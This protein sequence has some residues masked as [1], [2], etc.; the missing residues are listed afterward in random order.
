[1]RSRAAKTR[2]G[3]ALS[4]F[5]PLSRA[6]PTQD[7][8]RLWWAR[9]VSPISQARSFR[10]LADLA[11]SSP[12]L[13]RPLVSVLDEAALPDAVKQLLGGQRFTTVGSFL[14]QSVLH[15]LLQRQ[16][17][18]EITL[19]GFRDWLARGANSQLRLVS[20]GSSGE[21]ASG[22]STVGQLCRAAA[23]PD[24]DEWNAGM[25]SPA[26]PRILL[27]KTL[28]ALAQ[29]RLPLQAGRA[30]VDVLKGL[31]A[32]AK[33]GRATPTPAPPSTGN[34]RLDAFRH[35]LATMRERLREGWPPGLVPGRLQL[36]AERDDLELDLSLVGDERHLDRYDYSGQNG[37]YSQYDGAE[38][39]DDL[40]D[41]AGDFDA[42]YGGTKDG[43]RGQL[44]RRDGSPRKL[45]AGKLL[46][47]DLARAQHEPLLRCWCARAECIHRAVA[48]DLLLSTTESARNAPARLIAPLLVPAWQRALRSRASTRAASCRRSGWSCC[49]RVATGCGWW[50]CPTRWGGCSRRWPR[51]ARASRGRRCPAW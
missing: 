2:C 49:A 19:A 20:C 12:L 45:P 51:T 7:A 50:S 30:L 6:D 27:R 3:R 32:T 37:F 24:L 46:M 13:A 34:D 9:G 4:P 33:R 36:S 8:A 47:P 5:G 16:G 25:L 28:G 39:D 42:L 18:M 31:V 21:P 1:M 44:G 14:R 29:E 15:A 17:L 48:L 35:S 22:G 38:L 40:D 10:Q 41:G 43:A 26:L 23:I 11:G